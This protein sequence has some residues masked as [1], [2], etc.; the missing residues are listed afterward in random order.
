MSTS[1]GEMAIRTNGLATEKGKG[2]SGAHPSKYTIDKYHTNTN[3][4]RNTNTQI[5]YKGEMAI[6]TNGKGRRTSGDVPS[7]QPSFKCKYTNT[8][9]YKAMY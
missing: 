3:K 1:R 9:T 8:N 5:Q 7:I 6:R 4:N 2:T